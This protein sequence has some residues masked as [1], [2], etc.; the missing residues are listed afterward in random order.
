M[1]TGRRSCPDRCET[2]AVG[3]ADRGYTPEGT[4]VPR[5]RP[6][7][8]IEDPSAVAERVVRMVVD[9]VATAV[10][11]SPVEVDVASVCVHGDT[12]GAVEL[13]RSVRAALTAAGLTVAAFSG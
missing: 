4:L 8:L 12:P 10:D 11:G 9:G 7:A 13:A 2:A 3:F 1:S 5:G 6:G